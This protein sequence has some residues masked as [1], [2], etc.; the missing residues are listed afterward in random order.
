[1]VHPLPSFECEGL[2]QILFSISCAGKRRP[3]GAPLVVP[4]RL[5]ARHARTV[6]GRETREALVE[7]PFGL[8]G[9]STAEQG[10]ARFEPQETVARVLSAQRGELSERLVVASLTV[11]KKDEREPR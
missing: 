11:I 3:G 7:E 6:I 1:S 8:C 9:P 5:F 10:R 4:E 2:P